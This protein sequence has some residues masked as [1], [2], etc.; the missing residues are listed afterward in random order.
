MHARVNILKAIV[1]TL[2]LTWVGSSLRA[3]ESIKA[4]QLLPE[5][6]LAALVFPDLG[7]A[8][9]SW[10]KTRF[11]QM[12]AQ[13]EMQAFFKTPCTRL[14]TNYETIRQSSPIFPAFAD[15]DAGLLSGE[16]AVGVFPR[17]EGVPP[18]GAM[19]SITPKDPA[20]FL[21]MLPPDF[22]QALQTGELVPMGRQPDAPALVWKKQ[23]LIACVPQTEAPALLARLENPAAPGSLATAAAFASAR[24][25]MTNSAGWFY[26]NA[27]KIKQL[28]VPMAQGEPEMAQAVG[29]LQLFGIDD[30]TSISAS[31]GFS[32]ADVL[33]E[34]F[35]GL[36]PQPKSPLFALGDS[37]KPFPAD[38]LKLAPADA[39][40]V[41]AGRFSMASLIETIRKI[42][43]QFDPGAA[44]QVDQALEQAR[45]TLGFDLQ[46]DLLGQLG[47]EMLMVEPAVDTAPVL[48]FMPGMVL[49]VTIKEPAKVE[50]SL[51][52]LEKLV[53]GL[54]QTAMMQD[55]KPAFTELMM[56]ELR[57][58]EYR[59]RSIMYLYGILFTAPVSVSVC[60]DKLL[61]GTSVNAVR[62]LID[63][64]EQPTNILGNRSF[65]ETL[66]RVTGKPFDAQ[67]LPPSF[68]YGEDRSSGTGSLIFSGLGLGGSAVGMGFLQNTL[69][70]T[71]G[72]V[73]A[74]ENAAMLSCLSLNEAQDLYHQTDWDKND[75]N[76]YAQA[77]RG[78]FSLYDKKAGEGDML[79]ID[80]ALADAGGE[81]GGAK[82]KNGYRFKLL[83]EQGANVKG[84]AKPFIKDGKQTEGYAVVA[85]PVRYGQSGKR[86]FIVSEEG[87]IYAK[88]LGPQ[89]AEA[90][91]QMKVYNP[92]A[93]WTEVE[94]KFDDVPL[95]GDE[96]EQFLTSNGGRA[97]VRAVRDIDLALWPD[98]GFFVKH[99]RAT[100]GVAIRT[101]DGI[102]WRT[103]F[104][105]PAPA[106]N[107]G[108][109]TSIATVSVMA[110]LML[111]V[112]ARARTQARNA[113][114]ANNLGNLIKCCHLYSDTDKD[115]NFPKNGLELYPKYVKD[116]RVFQNPNY[117]AQDAAYYYIPGSSPVD[118]TNV[119]FFEWVPEG[120]EDQGRNIAIGA[121]S[122]EW[123]QAAEFQQRMEE[124][125]KALKEKGIEMKPI[126]LPVS[127]LQQKGPGDF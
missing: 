90:V 25:P 66:A 74:N 87:S 106:T 68:V 124:T 92:D 62:R 35:V 42:S 85:Y 80:E 39:P 9:A 127:K 40:Y 71:A 11:A 109:L 52:K 121:G 34:T 20:A 61:V 51:V 13:P 70:A 123:V 100:G 88:D 122:I 95:A 99:R 104:P 108:S 119:I 56:P 8:R 19:L 3:G 91:A 93:T 44:A 10:G 38:L 23:R 33:M 17:K 50:Q 24:K 15:L 22:R 53:T 21:R 48:S 14:M 54:I 78:D 43:G 98:E 125:A 69:A 94:P 112:L 81:P 30:L 103:E 36:V 41:W 86:C 18:V 57:R 16:L 111:P 2:S 120:K 27:P 101:P 45:K 126:P 118:A 1:L 97:A 32:D 58:T 31:L 37:T 4:E 7:A 117:P 29:I 12:L 5:D 65:Q 72:P 84:G 28:L 73:A 75:V 82:D 60:G 102:L 114:S 96:V 47:D 77:F 79:L 105:P 55:E 89:T 116:V 110:G 49:C 59:G 26:A 83:K 63:Q 107:T 67:A 64:L 6:T 46:A 76:E 115:G 113:S